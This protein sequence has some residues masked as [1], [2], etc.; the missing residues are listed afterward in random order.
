[1]RDQVA[2]FTMTQCRTQWIVLTSPK[3]PFSVFMQCLINA[4]SEDFKINKWN[5]CHWMSANRLNLLLFLKTWK[6]FSP[7]LWVFTT[8][9]IFLWLTMRLSSRPID[10][11]RGQQKHGQSYS[12]QLIMIHFIHNQLHLIRI[13]VT[14][15]GHL[16]TSNTRLTDRAIKSL[17]AAAS[18]LRCSAVRVPESNSKEQWSGSFEEFYWADVPS[19]EL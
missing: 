8:G 13:L 18:F 3:C 19:C 17:K 16:G 5:S 1:M 12:E 14:S 7:Q 2:N 11:G 9:Y 4:L 10:E 15:E 6:S